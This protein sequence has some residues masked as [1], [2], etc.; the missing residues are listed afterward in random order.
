MDG[1]HL[2]AILSHLGLS[3]EALG[4]LDVLP[5]PTVIANAMGV[6][7]YANQA[8][9]DLL[10][11]QYPSE[12]VAADLTVMDLIAPEQRDTA[13]AMTK[14]GLGITAQSSSKGILQLRDG[15]RVQVRATRVPILN[16]EQELQGLLITGHSVGDSKRD[17]L[18]DSE[19]LNQFRN[20]LD[21]SP[22]GTVVVVGGSI[23]Y[24][25]P[26]FSALYGATDI[27]KVQ[28]L[29][30]RE[31]IHPDDWAFVTELDQRMVETGEPIV[32]HPERLIRA[33]G[34]VVSA[35]VSASRQSF[36]GRIGALVTFRDVSER[37]A[38]FDSL[39]ESEESYRGIVQESSEATLICRDDNMLFVNS[40]ALSMFG[41]EHRADLA[42]QSISLLGSEEA[43]FLLKEI[44]SVS[45]SKTATH[46]LPGRLKRS[47]GDL[48]N[49]EINVSPTWYRGEEA[50]QIIIRDIT[51]RK[52]VENS[53]RDSELKWRTLF[54]S[55][56]DPILLMDLE[57]KILEVNQATVALLGYDS[58][59]SLLD[60]KSSPLQMMLV[61]DKER[62]TGVLETL[63]EGGSPHTGPNLYTVRDKSDE[64]IRVS[65]Q[66]MPLKDSEG[67]VVS[68]MAI[69]RDVTEEE[70]LLASLKE[71]ESILAA[72]FDQSTLGLARISLVG[73]P[74]RF[75]ESFQ[76]LLGYSE[77]ELR[78]LNPAQ[79]THP[80]DF[81]ADYDLMMEVMSGARDSYSIEKRMSRKDREY[82]WVD[83][84]VT[85][86][87]KADGTPW[88]ALSTLA[89]ISARKKLESQLIQSEKLGAIGELL[90]GAAH[91]INNPL[92]V[93]MANAQ[94]ISKSAGDKII[95]DSA[96]LIR[97]Y[98]GRASRVVDGLLAFSRSQVPRKAVIDIRAA[99]EEALS[100]YSAS[101]DFEIVDIIAD[102]PDEPLWVYAD[103]MQVEQVI[104]N[105][106]INGGRSV[107][108]K[109]EGPGE[110]RLTIAR[111]TESPE[112][113]IR[114]E[115]SDSG[116]GIP[117]KIR[118]KVFE[119]FFTTK[120]VGEGTGLG[121]SIAY[122]L[123]QEND[124]EIFCSNNDSGGATFTVILPRVPG[125]P[126]GNQYIKGI[127]EG[128]QSTISTTVYD[129]D[130][131]H[132]RILTS[133]LAPLG[134]S[135][136]FMDSPIE[137]IAEVID[138]RADKA[139]C[140]ISSEAEYFESLREMVQ[141]EA[142]G[143]SG[144]VVLAATPTD[145]PVA[146]LASQAGI[147][148]IFTPYRLRDIADSMT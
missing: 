51:E 67:N 1:K 53:I 113:K 12:I 121:L 109:G 44:R 95:R 47:S 142:T 46:D 56:P 85:I 65:A 120:P 87:R 108:E 4:L 66:S 69:A 6:Y 2:D 57:G 94:L 79:L 82:V 97:K 80:E 59:E 74:D 91:E 146:E 130:T 5:E 20:V 27:E 41:Y 131:S 114:I 106:L 25:N 63:W 104:L 22:D 58:R 137:A 89:D 14:Q 119:P 13:L 3:K 124:G 127:R 96:D 99:A 147:D 90:S 33:D 38:L 98:A 28:G 11:F 29:K 84:S 10:H 70:R 7:V 62:A 43:D 86:V 122:G 92:A 100:L 102:Q 50:I 18:A 55:A 117:D 54:E 110:V 77:E 39:A 125:L 23:V 81:Q 133:L 93:V 26:V 118:D 64:V 139:L 112:E 68:F 141:G 128:Q 16:D 49:T 48:F 136:T 8:M 88:Y 76:Q 105:L 30:I 115:V 17:D 60:D 24:A 31:I 103:M 143:L 45:G 32:G 42:G 61:E 75:N 72:M 52:R 123:V 83:L 15:S 111:D 19:I 71:S 129:D 78:A 36:D 101:M 140:A 34:S 135:L 116:G 134:H 37:Q 21:V 132:G 148:M 9:A 138:D 107:I 145:I 144:R 73:E 126:E 35:E 40:A